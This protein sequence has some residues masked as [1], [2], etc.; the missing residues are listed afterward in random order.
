MKEQINYCEFSIDCNVFST[1]PECSSDP[2]RCVYHKRYVDKKNQL[3][4]VPMSES[5]VA[6]LRLDGL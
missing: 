1:R 4:R 2:D 5:L 3:E 6:T